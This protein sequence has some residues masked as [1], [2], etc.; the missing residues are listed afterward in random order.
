MRT[1]KFEIALLLL[2][3]LLGVALRSVEVLNK[4]FL[5]GIDQGRDYLAVEKIV[6]EGKLTLIGPEI[7]AGFA[8][9][10][11]VFH[12]P[13]Y[14][15]SLILPFL[16]WNGDP[17]GGLVLMF[18]FGV[19]SLFLFFFIANKIFGFKAAMI[20]TFLFGLSPP[21]TSQSRFM[22][23]SHPST[24]FVLLAF[25]FTYKMIK[26]PKKY[27]FLATFF[28]GMIY[29]FELAISIPLVISQF[30]FAILVLKIKNIRL[31]LLGVFGV[32]I[33]HFPFFLFDLRHNFMQMRSIFGSLFSSLTKQGSVDSA[34]LFADHLV[35][36]WHNFRNTFV[37]SWIFPLLLLVLMLYILHEVKRGK[38][39][40]PKAP[41]I[42]FLLIMP[43]VSFIVFLFLKTAVWDFYLIQL[44]LV[45]IL[46]FSY[47][48]V[49]IKTPKIRI[50][51]IA[52]LVFMIPGLF[53]E[54]RRVY[55]DYHD[56]GGTAKIKGK[57][58]AID[59]LYQEAAG[60]K[61][62][63]LVFTPPVYDYAYQ[64]LFNWYGA[65]KYGFVPGHE[66]GGELYL[67][68]EP[69]SSGLWHKG[70]LETVIGPGEVI[71]EEKLP[72]GFIVQKR[73]DKKP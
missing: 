40:L 27:F 13:Y 16:I 29:G 31:Y 70:W 10:N 53:K 3:I 68:M 2:I 62:N 51:F 23:N 19:S 17:Y 42:G 56:F 60:K 11:G 73:Y 52:L 15:Y 49:H 9:L 34:N 44:H 14:F 48:T 69:E 35:N 63:V 41:F 47:F 67:L 7:G 21:I 33:A 61:F 4:N 6:R 1:K 5:F 72:S 22:W 37:L 45:Y 25:W 43:V 32:L 18:L 24:F 57:I 65:K 64:Y 55:V 30:L 39:L 71:K 8:S 54:F 26:N 66:R 28:A 20:A 36:F 12:G 59:Y 46:L 58:E 50:L 38:I